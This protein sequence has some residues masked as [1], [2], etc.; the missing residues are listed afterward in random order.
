MLRRSADAAKVLSLAFI[1]FYLLLP[2]FAAAQQ[3]QYL[4]DGYPHNDE[5]LHSDSPKKGGLPGARDPFES[6]KLPTDP[7]LEQVHQYLKDTAVVS[8]SESAIATLAPASLGDVVRAPPARQSGKSATLSRPPALLNA[9]SLQDW[10]VED[11]VLLATVD[12][13]IHAR[14]RR[15]GAPRWALEVDRSMVETAYHRRNKTDKIEPRP[16]DN[17]L[18]IVEPS[19]DG[20]IYIYTPGPNPSL[21]KLELT[22]KKLVEELSPYAGDD[23]RVVYTAE[24]RTTLYTVDAANGRVLKTFSSAGSSVNDDA[25]CPRVTGL[26]YLDDEECGSG[27]LLTLGRIEYTVA[28]Q[29]RDTGDPICT[30]RYSEWGP[31]N[32]DSDLQSQYISTMD[33]K[34]IYSRHDGSIF[35]FDHTQMDERRKLYTQKFSSPVARV[36][37]VARPLESDSH[38]T[39]LIILPQPTGPT[40][41]EGLSNSFSDRTNRIFVNHTEQGA[42]Y[43]MSED[44]YPLVTGG[45]PLAQCYNS[46]WLDTIGSLDFSHLSKAQDALVGVHAIAPFQDRKRSFPT[47]PGPEKE[48]AN[49]TPLNPILQPPHSSAIPTIGMAEPPPSNLHWTLLSVVLSILGTWIY[50]HRRELTTTLRK[51]LQLKGKSNTAADTSL[52]AEPAKDLETLRPLSG[53]NMELQGETAEGLQ[54]GVPLV[55]QTSAATAEANPVPQS[56]AKDK[57]IQS[58]DVPDNSNAEEPAP[59][60]PKK[61]KAHRGQRGGR[62]HRKKNA[63]KKENVDEVE[64]ILDEVQDVQGGPSIEPDVI[65][66]NVAKSDS[67]TDVIEPFQINNLVVTDEVL[68]YGSSGT[69]VFKGSFEGREVAVK[70]MLRQ[71]FNVASHEVGLL[72]ESD[73]HANVIRYFC[74]Q[75]SSLFHYIALE[76][77]HASVQDVVE[78]PVE[79]PKLAKA[80]SLDMPHIM[81]Q[82]AAGVRHLHALRIVHRDLK[83]QNILVANPKLSPANPDAVVPPRILISDFGL[84]KKLENELSYLGTSMTH[85]AGTPGWRAP[86]LLLLDKDKAGSADFYTT[87]SGLSS[88]ASNSAAGGTKSTRRATRAID[89]FSLGCVYFYV[90]TGGLHPFGDSYMR[91]ANALKGNFDL[92]PL[93]SLGDYASE[94]K[95]LIGRMIALE[96]RQRP[97]ATSVMI[98][99]FFWPPEKRLNFLC[100]VSDHFEFECRDPPSPHLQILE[101][102]A[103]EVIN[104]DFLR[105]LHKDFVD[106][107]G[108][109]RKYTGTKMLDLLR[110]L[111]NKKN[112]YQDMPDDVKARVGP[113]PAGYLHYWT[114]R[115]PD[116]LLQC[117]NAIVS[118]ELQGRD[119]F[120]PYFTPPP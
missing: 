49:D 9:R 115:F 13:T 96:P 118:C 10:E 71:F 88:E 84:C 6:S 110:A 105:K 92:E 101:S 73:D 31:N 107:L 3:K 80:W 57:A 67:V 90:L 111:R 64:R 50:L 93:D 97:D 56:A 48:L 23:P 35:G 7:R 58:G 77:C 42:W 87:A 36:F 79:F 34:Y 81:L 20:S 51:K 74:R 112:H 99:P 44:S 68:G 69:M 83:P 98:H 18:W 59:S 21:Q 39:P 102:V 109:Q 19:Q 65:T 43:A 72:Q 12:G 25:S 100:D 63:N 82:I 78:R 54:G 60:P 30:I 33:Q 120:K 37:D 26:E 108:K 70:R 85:A 103:A 41:G 106:T 76:L 47:L 55:E 22:V 117:H 29:S 8:N 116:L 5:I 62:Q 104:G 95:D 1:A 119:R 61:K 14:D 114:V 32:R 27:G 75:E 46:D 52:S 28:I 86:E 17:L 24:K 66:V 91:E 45:A 4:Q 38:D 94:A 40:D 113:L 11:F 15:T 2:V 89:I 16:E 53:P